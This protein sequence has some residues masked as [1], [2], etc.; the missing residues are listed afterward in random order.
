MITLLK[1]GRMSLTKIQDFNVTLTRTEGKGAGTAEN[2]DRILDY[3]SDYKA[4]ISVKFAE[5]SL[6]EYSV[7]MGVLTAYD[8]FQLTYW[9]GRY[10]TVWVTAGD[11]ECELLKSET[12]PNTEKYNRWNVSVTFTQ[13]EDSEVT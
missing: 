5:L 8:K 9:R 7:L 1:I 3:L 13:I 10:I 6:N 11:L 4:V 12:K 2:G